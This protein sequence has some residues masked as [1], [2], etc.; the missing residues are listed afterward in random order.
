MNDVREK[1]YDNISGLNSDGLHLIREEQKIFHKH[2]VEIGK[3]KYMLH[4]ERRWSTELPDT[5][6][7]LQIIQHLD[8]MIQIHAP[9][10]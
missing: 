10:I 9:T 7:A 6:L 4:H 3:E 8:M 1:S 2:Y 5:L